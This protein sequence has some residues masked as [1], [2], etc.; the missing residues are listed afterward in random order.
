MKIL[1]V[2]TVKGTGGGPDKTILKSCNYLANHGHTAEAFY[3]L[4]GR[5]DPGTIARTA[6]KLGVQL[7]ISRENGPVSVPSLRAFYRVLKKGEYDIVHTHEYKSTALAPLFRHGNGY[8]MVAT[9]HGYNRTSI[10]EIFYYGLERFCF[11]RADAVVA[12]SNEMVEF[13]KQKGVSPARLHRIPNGIETQGHEP[14]LGKVRKDRIRLLY[15]GRLSQ[16]KDPALLLDVMAILRRRG[17]NAQLVLAGAGPEQKNL[18]K[19]AMELGLAED[20]KMPGFVAEVFSLFQE[21]DILINPSR[22]ECMPNTILE[23]M[24]AG[25]PV[26]ATAVGGIG[27]MIR[28]GRDG[29]LCPPGDPAALAAAVVRVIEDPD[30]ARRL[31]DSAYQRVMDQFTFEKH[32]EAT[33]ALYTQLLA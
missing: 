20:V 12:P 4:D 24:L 2:R 33:L 10:R 14:P 6:G 19:K 5:N 13:L 30:L 8:K 17:F 16:E 23:A 28:D 21:A 22:T 27:E 25:V 29:V 18:E 3:F 31:T 9:A 15:L 7:T 1:H 32:M 11:K 26:V